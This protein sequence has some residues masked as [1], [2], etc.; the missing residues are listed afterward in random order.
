M[1]LL[2]DFEMANDTPGQVVGNVQRSRSAEDLKTLYGSD[3][4]DHPERAFDAILEAL[5]VFQQDPATFAPF[6]SKYDAFLRGQVALTDT[7]T[8]GLRLF[9][10]PDKG[11]C[12]SCHKSRP[13]AAGA[14]PLFTDYGLIAVG[15]PRNLAIPANADPTF[16][17]LGLCGPVRTDLSDHPDYCGLFKAPSLRNV[18]VRRSFFHNGVFH[19]LRDAVAFYATRDT[20]PGRWYPT[21]AAGQVRKFDDL[22]A[23]YHEN[24]NFEPPFDRHAGNAPALTDDDVDDIVTFLRTLTDGY[25]TGTDPQTAGGR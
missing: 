21:D 15:V 9:E 13:T 3:I 5:E 4:F 6:S 1:P 7:E 17:D 19:S 18:A 16:F 10:D 24:I 23:A 8:R 12:A 14:L 22:P 2:S 11:N 25:R 20:D